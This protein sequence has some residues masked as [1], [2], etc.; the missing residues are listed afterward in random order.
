[1]GKFNES[2]KHLVIQRYLNE[3]IGYRELANEV[4]IDESALRYWVK[5]YEYHGESAFCFPYTN[6]PLAFKLKVIQ[7][8]EEK[9]FSIR[10]ASAIF[11]IPDCSMVRKWKKKW[12]NGGFDALKPKEKGIPCMTS[13]KKKNVD[14]NILDKDTE[15]SVEEMQKELEFLRMENAYFKKVESLSSKQGKITKKDKAKVVYELR[16]IFSVKKLIKLA[17]IPRSTY[18]Y[19]V[20]TF[21]LPDKNAELKT[22]IQSIYEEHNGLYGY[23]RI[24]EELNNRGYKVNHKKVQRLMKVLGLKCMVR[25]KKY[26]SYKGNVGKIAPNILERNFNAEKPNQKWVTDITEFKLFGEKLYLSPVLDLFNSEIVTYTIGTRPTYSLVAEMLDKSFERLTDDDNLII[27]SDQGWH[28]QMKKYRQSLKK[29][30]ITQSMS[31]KGNC[32]D[33]A[34][35]ENFFGIMKSEF[36]YRNEF[37]DIDHFKHELKKYIYYYNNIRIKTKLKGKSPIQ[38]RTLTQTAA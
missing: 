12:D 6:Y 25:M 32:Y 23:R 21:N 29:Q 3:R 13:H 7:F 5:L 20:N 1:M 38:Y 4:G 30:G 17:K 14:K 36:L 37:K 18:Y 11:H 8:I 2:E 28:Y 33:N 19:W 35:I 15:G 34:V 24:Q 10:E 9:Q 22:L 16:N 27:H 31:R 26:R